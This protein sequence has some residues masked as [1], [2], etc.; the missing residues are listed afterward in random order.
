MQEDIEEVEGERV[1]TTGQP[2]VQAESENGKRTVRLVARF[3]R[4]ITTPEIMRED[5]LDGSSSWIHVFIIDDC[6]TVV[7][8][9]TSKATVGVAG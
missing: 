3:E 7:K 8:D 5:L 6:L 4:N 1:S 9:K 2:K